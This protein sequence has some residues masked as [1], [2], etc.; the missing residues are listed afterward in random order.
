MDE[1]GIEIQL[2]YEDDYILDLTF[3]AN[4]GGFQGKVQW[5]CNPDDLKNIGEALSPFPNKIPDEYIFDV[6]TNWSHLSIKAY[7]F[8]RSGHC[9]LQ[10]YIN[11]NKKN[12]DE[13][14][15]RF[16]IVVEAWAIHR[17][18]ELLKKFS[19]LKYSYLKWSPN[20]DNDL[21]V[22]NKK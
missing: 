14:E 9:A 4:N 3:T 16:S 2:G 7:N 17:L 5:Y 18:G 8:D 21:L 20:P 1:I 15:C 11:N 10:I 6:D 13:G 19:T 12:P 22:E